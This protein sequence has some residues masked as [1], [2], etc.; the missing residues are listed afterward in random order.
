MHVIQFGWMWKRVNP[1]YQAVCSA[2]L[3][4]FR[5]TASQTGG[6]NT[7]E[8]PFLPQGGY[9]DGAPAL[10]RSQAWS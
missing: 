3:H 7:H 4:C 2:R 9:G 10:R 8:F 6:S 1:L 5:E